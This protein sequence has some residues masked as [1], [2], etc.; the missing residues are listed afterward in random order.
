VE[1]S[2]KAGDPIMLERYL[3]KL[4]AS[5][6]VDTIKSGLSGSFNEL[7]LIHPSR[8]LIA[9]VIRAKLIEIAEEISRRGP[10]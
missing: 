6:R 1:N 3:D 10:G 9:P 7:F 2:L 4:S 5:F 8:E